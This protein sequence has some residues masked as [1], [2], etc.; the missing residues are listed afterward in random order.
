MFQV[1]I[2]AQIHTSITHIQILALELAKVKRN[3]MMQR[4]IVKVKESI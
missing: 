3:G 4:V 1:Q 2:H